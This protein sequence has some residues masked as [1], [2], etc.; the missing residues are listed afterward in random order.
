MLIRHQKNIENALNKKQFVILINEQKI[1]IEN[2]FSDK[3]GSIHVIKY[4]EDDKI[5]T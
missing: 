3:T 5:S 2:L 4:T 1:D